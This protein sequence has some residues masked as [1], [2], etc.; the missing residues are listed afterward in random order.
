VQLEAGTG[1]VPF[2]PKDSRG[3]Q[4]VNAADKKPGGRWLLE[5]R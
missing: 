4:V 5:A 3:K 2:V 1:S